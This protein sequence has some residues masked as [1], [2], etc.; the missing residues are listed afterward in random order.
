MVDLLHR[1]GLAGGF[2]LKA[3][4][5]AEDDAIQSFPVVPT[6]L[7]ARYPGDNSYRSSTGNY[8]L[9]VTSAPTQISATY[10]SLRRILMFLVGKPGAHS[11]V[12]TIQLNSG[13]EP[14]GSDQHST[15]VPRSSRA[16]FRTSRSQGIPQ[17]SRRKPDGTITATFTTSGTHQIT[18]NYSGDSNYAAA[19][20]LRVQCLGAFYATSGRRNSECDK[21]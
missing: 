10:V 16:Q 13:A 3:G 19:T 12:V 11:C 1:L 4:G 9:T 5:L 2:R 14:T 15:T 21:H 18:A 8:T 17:E 7:T 6:K 20:W